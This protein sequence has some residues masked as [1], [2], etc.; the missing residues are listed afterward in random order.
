MNDKI[1]PRSWHTWHA[2]GFTEKHNKYSWHSIFH[3]SLSCTARPRVSPIDAVEQAF[4][5]HV[6]QQPKQRLTTDLNSFNVFLFL[7]NFLQQQ[8]ACTL[9]YGM[10][11]DLEN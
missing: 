5:M 7:P 6:L 3:L 9:N 1:T 2:L 10:H 4:V 11:G 8:F